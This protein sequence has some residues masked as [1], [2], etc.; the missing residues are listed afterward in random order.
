[1]KKR[2]KELVVD[3]FIQLKARIFRT[4]NGEFIQ[5]VESGSL[6]ENIGQ[7]SKVYKYLCRKGVFS[8]AAEL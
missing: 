6:N 8:I 3:F 1:M 2:K 4:G 7:L 5:A